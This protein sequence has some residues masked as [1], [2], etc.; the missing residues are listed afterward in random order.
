MSFIDCITI[1]IVF[2]IDVYFPSILNFNE[3]IYIVI[4]TSIILVL[5]TRPS[6]AEHKIIIKTTGKLKL[7]ILFDLLFCTFALQLL[8]L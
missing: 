3:T 4:T 6:I 1:I 5:N 8:V 7:L 2:F